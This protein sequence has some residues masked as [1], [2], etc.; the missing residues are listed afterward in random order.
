[1]TPES[2]EQ[3]GLYRC[4]NCDKRYKNKNSFNCHL[5]Y[6]CGKVQRFYCPY[7]DHITHRKYDMNV[8]VTRV[9]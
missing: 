8:H 9:H 6:N 3:E 2:V 5:R 7:C 4:P 1:M